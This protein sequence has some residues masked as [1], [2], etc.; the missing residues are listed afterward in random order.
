MIETTLK[1]CQK[2]ADDE[3]I[4]L[5]FARPP[6]D[7]AVF[8]DERLIRQVV[9]NLISNAVKFTPAGGRV[10]I[11]IHASR[12]AG[13]T[14]SVKDTGIGIASKDLDRVLR[15]FEQVESSL[16]RSHGGTGLGLPYSK[17]V[18]EIHGGTLKL[19][20]QVNVGTTVRV[21]LA[22]SRIRASAAPAHR[23]VALL[24]AG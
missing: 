3:N 4:E 21:Q 18:I 23:T 2:K 5:E 13:V 6:T 10:S 16:S 17:K 22:A 14:L 8:A 15:P 20:S 11:D 9:L 12:E 1:M 19:S 24:Q 7:F